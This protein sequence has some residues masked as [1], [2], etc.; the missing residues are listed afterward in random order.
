MPRYQK[1]IPHFYSVFQSSESKL[2]PYF[3][4]SEFPRWRMP[5]MSPIFPRH[6]RI[7]RQGL[8]LLSRYF[9]KQRRRHHFD[10]NTPYFNLI[11][12]KSAAPP[13]LPKWAIAQ[14]WKRLERDNRFCLLTQL[15]P[16]K[17]PPGYHI[18]IGHYFDTKIR[19]ADR[20]LIRNSFTYLNWRVVDEIDKA[21]AKLNEP[22]TV[23]IFNRHSVAVASGTV[24]CRG[25]LAYL[26]AGNV[27][28]NYRRRGLWKLLIAV[29][30]MISYAQGARLWLY[31][32]DNQL[33]QNRGDLVYR[34]WIYRQGH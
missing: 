14:G 11:G 15:R 18:K 13:K 28:H 8:N 16:I 27:A 23:L 22:L 3:T 30:Q 4:M 21:V 12:E 2:Q 7:N 17:L 25:H 9:A 33:I 1:E 34:N 19:A 6:N 31:T 5:I 20:A 32:S 24:F 26:F 29:R 10:M